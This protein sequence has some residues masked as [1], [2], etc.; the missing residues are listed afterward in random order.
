M[1]D[2]SAQ[3][4]FISNPL[5]LWKPSWAAFKLNLKSYIYILLLILVTFFVVLGSILFFAALGLKS[6][7]PWYSALIAV[8]SLAGA[9]ILLTTG[10][11]CNYLNLASA[12]GRK[13]RV[14]EVFKIIRPKILLYFALI[15]LIGFITVMGLLLLV[16]PG[17]IAFVRLSLA[18]YVFFHENLGI[19]ASIKRSW[20]LSSGQFKETLGL[21]SVSWAA[22]IIT[23][24]PIIGQVVVFIIGSVYSVALP[25]RYLQLL[26]VED[27]SL[28]KPPIHHMN[29]FI[30]A[31]G[32]IVAL[33]F[34]GNGA[35]HDYKYF[36]DHSSAVTTAR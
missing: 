14:R 36:K 30:I 25:I 18:P 12:E 17:I 24:I 21:L 29:F 11:I 19:M 31:L 9:A 23:I 32:L 34:S 35:Y 13:L 3:S 6:G 22:N 33:V 8:L 2:D 7:V 28:V 1:E 15:I 26:K 27:K 16:V 20:A 4:K 5:D 10:P